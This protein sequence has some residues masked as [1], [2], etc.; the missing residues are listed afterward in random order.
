MRKQYH[1]VKK[2]NFV[3]FA[4]FGAPTNNFDFFVR[5]KGDHKGVSDGVYQDVFLY[6]FKVT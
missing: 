6:T 3:P 5:L 2:V 1:F 4:A